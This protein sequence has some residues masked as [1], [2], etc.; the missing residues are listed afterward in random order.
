LSGTGGL[1]IAFEFLKSYFPV[2]DVYVSNPSWPIHQK[3]IEGSGLNF[4]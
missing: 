2:K 4:K 1:K 3:L